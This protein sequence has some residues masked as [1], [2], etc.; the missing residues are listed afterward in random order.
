VPGTVVGCRQS[1]Q[2]SLCNS[3]RSEI[4]I[5]VLNF[6]SIFTV[7]SE[8]LTILSQRL[9]VCALFLSHLIIIPVQRLMLAA[10]THGVRFG[11]R[12]AAIGGRS[13]A[14]FA[15][16]RE[17][18]RGASTSEAR[19]RMEGIIATK[20][21][22]YLNSLLSSLFDTRMHFFGSSISDIF[23]LVF[24]ELLNYCLQVFLFAY[25][26]SHITIRA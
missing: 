26:V 4:S 22:E 19:G 10:W 7:S 14:L 11:E 18:R 23:H 17:H 13:D 15:S 24:I 16:N 9:V 5:S 3:T 6:S 25:F 12:A 1:Y 20:S 21:R 2:K 8:N